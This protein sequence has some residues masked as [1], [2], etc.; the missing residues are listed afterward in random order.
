MILIP[1][2]SSGAC[3]GVH[4]QSG[5]VQTGQALRLRRQPVSPEMLFWTAEELRAFLDQP[6]V[7]RRA[8]DRGVPARLD[9]Q[10]S[11]RDASGCARQMWTSRPPPVGA[12]IGDGRPKGVGEEIIVGRP[13]SGKARTL[14]STH[15]PRPTPRACK[16]AQGTLSLAPAQAEAYVL[17]NFDKRRALR[18]VLPEVRRRR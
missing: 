2:G 16:A 17:A 13:K 4:G 11:R 7:R 18:R 14:M 8:D 3:F 5:A 9:W 10:A 1:R 6:S 15:R 12:P